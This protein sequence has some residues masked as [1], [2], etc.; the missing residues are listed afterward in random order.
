[1]NIGLSLLLPV[2]KAFGDKIRYDL[3]F[4]PIIAIGLIVILIV[5]SAIIFLIVLAVKYLT[6]IRKNKTK[7]D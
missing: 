2:L 1:M 5:G 4:G 6:R 7:N 3:S